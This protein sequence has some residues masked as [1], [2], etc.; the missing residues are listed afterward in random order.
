MLTIL[1]KLPDGIL[2][3]DADQLHEILNGPTLIHLVGIRAQPVFIS[4]LLHGN[5]HSGWQVIQELLRNVTDKLPRSIS[6]FIGNVSAAS[7]C[8]RHLPEQLDYNRIWDGKGDSA[9]HTM[10]R[11]VIEEMQSRS[12]FAVIDIHNNTGFNPYYACINKLDDHFKYFA[13]QFGPLIVYF[14]QPDSVLSIAFSK[15]CPTVTVE[16][17]LS[18]DINGI[19]RVVTFID[20]T[21][22]LKSFPDTVTDVD[23]ISIYQTVAIVK[24]PTEVSIGFGD[25]DS[26]VQFDADL[27]QFNFREIHEN[28][29]IAKL[30]PNNIGRII[31]VNDDEKDV[32][33]Y[34][35]YQQDG[36]IKTRISIIPAMLTQNVDIVKNDCLCYLMT[37]I[38]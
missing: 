29:K 33:N 19:Q 16:C 35:F 5:E 8:L 27:E 10:V 7:Q 6:I 18:G 28:S 31:A 25:S 32:T 9:E 38:E 21:I 17:G 3:Y 11:Q 22:S 23:L 4:V 12:V 13:R 24:I 37:Q 15:L 14:K 2:N 26:D 36:Y 20:N 1:N 30:A 34:Y